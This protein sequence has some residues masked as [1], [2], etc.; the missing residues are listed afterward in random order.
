MSAPAILAIAKVEDRP[1]VHT[2]PTGLKESIA[3]NDPLRDV[4]TEQ[5]HSNFKRNFQ[6]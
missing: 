4:R 3:R 5:D 2:R 1:R 6:T